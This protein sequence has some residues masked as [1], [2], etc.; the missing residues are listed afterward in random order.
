MGWA[1]S[2]LLTS[3]LM[4]VHAWG[5]CRDSR[6][7]VW[8][9]GV[10]EAWGKLGVIVWLVRDLEQR[11]CVILV[12]TVKPDRIWA[13]KKWSLLKGGLSIEFIMYGIA[14]FE[15]PLNRGGL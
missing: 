5:I 7:R 2:S 6:P 11:V 3:V 13:K 15:R 14:T 9:V 8:C 12:N 4:C 10:L 1:G